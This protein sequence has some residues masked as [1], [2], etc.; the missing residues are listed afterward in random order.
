MNH[1]LPDAWQMSNLTSRFYDCLDS[2][3]YA[4]VMSCFSEN[5]VWFRRGGQVTGHPAIREALDG[6]PLN[7]HTSHMVTNVRVEQSSSTEGAVTFCM[8]GYPYTGEIAPGKHVAQPGAHIV[9][10]YRDTMQKIGGKWL[11][12]EKKPIRTAYKDE[13]HLP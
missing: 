9:A 5:G 8:T 13:Q 7:F 12:V 3:D 1:F 10:M 6:R 4:G 11:I 2:R